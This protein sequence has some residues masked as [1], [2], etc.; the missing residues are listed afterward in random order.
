M[1]W[2]KALFCILNSFDMLNNNIRCIET[3][4]FLSFAKPCYVKQQ[5]KMYWNALIEIASADWFMLNNNIRCIETSTLPLGYRMNKVKQQH[6]MYWNMPL[7]ILLDTQ[8][9]VKQQHK[10]YWNCFSKSMS[11]IKSM[12]NNNIRCI[13]T[14]DLVGT[15]RIFYQVKQQHKMY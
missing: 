11:L 14:D 1:Y 4:Y 2:N 5:H 7:Y 3:T 12:L 10:M 6:K 13:E 8:P 15:Y 9:L